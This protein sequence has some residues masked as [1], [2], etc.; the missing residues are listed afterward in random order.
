MEEKTNTELLH[1]LSLKQ[2]EMLIVGGVTDVE[3]FDESEV[4]L[5]TVCGELKISGSN[6]H[7]S[8]LQLETGDVRLTGRVDGMVYTVHEPPRPLLKRLFR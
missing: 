4:K 1:S 6:L 2:R 3:S 8:Q 7:I 5:V